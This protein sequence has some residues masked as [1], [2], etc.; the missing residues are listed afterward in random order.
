MP[1]V[2]FAAKRNKRKMKK[3]K[4]HIKALLREGISVVMR[5]DDFRYSELEEF[6]RLSNSSETNLTLVVGDDLTFDEAMQLAHI[7][8]GHICLNL[9]NA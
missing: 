8:H 4:E 6:A 7:S 3:S 5:T 2:T 1:K 9:T